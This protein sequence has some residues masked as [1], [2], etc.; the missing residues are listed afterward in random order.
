MKEYT[1]FDTTGR[2][3]D[4]GL[5]LEDVF[6]TYSSEEIIEGQ[7]NDRLY[8]ILNG[9][10]TLRPTLQLVKNTLIANGTDE[11]IIT[12]L[13]VPFTISIDDIM[14]ET[15]DGEF[16]FSTYVKGFYSIKAMTFPYRDASLII[17]AI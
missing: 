9:Q 1:K 10:P 4:Y 2:I 5:M 7:Y 17:E 8:Y 14:Y 16:I 12:N 6:N 3:S 11:I 15:T 13:P